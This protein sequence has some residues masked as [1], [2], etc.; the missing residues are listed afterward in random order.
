MGQTEVAGSK[1]V[2]GAGA[3]PG[4]VPAGKHRAAALNQQEHAETCWNRTKPPDVEHLNRRPG[5]TALFRLPALCSPLVGSALFGF[6]CLVSGGL[7]FWQDSW[8]R[9]AMKAARSIYYRLSAAITQPADHSDSDRGHAPRTLLDP[10]RGRSLTCQTRNPAKIQPQQTF[11]SHVLIF[12]GRRCHKAPM[13]HLK[14]EHRSLCS[15][16]HVGADSGKPLVG[17]EHV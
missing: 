12:T 9:V 17:A 6:P 1:A 15:W 2:L 3:G 5:D 14:Y 4:R 8:L 16:L 7:T 11:M 10:P 13:K